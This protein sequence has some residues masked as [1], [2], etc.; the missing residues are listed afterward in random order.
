MSEKQA[1]RIFKDNGQLIITVDC[2][3]IN[4]ENAVIKMV[5]SLL[6]DALIP[7]EVQSLE[8]M[9]EDEAPDVEE[10][11]LAYTNI[12]EDI[13]EIRQGVYMGLTPDEAIAKHGKEAFTAFVKDWDSFYRY[14]LCS[15][16]IRRA[17][18]SF[19]DKFPMFRQVT[20]IS[21]D[22]LN[23]FLACFADIST[24]IRQ[25]VAM[26]NCATVEQFLYMATFDE[27]WN[28]FA[29]RVVDELSKVE[30]S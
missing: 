7:T 28:L 12:Q 6:G 15:E 14:E 16:D 4:I 13:H 25:E 20:S 18:Y 11:D 22:K 21:A 8:P 23:A 9:A 3:S 17:V 29:G 26:K 27:K 24:S 2:S 19:R 1:V 5:E 30:L 10:A